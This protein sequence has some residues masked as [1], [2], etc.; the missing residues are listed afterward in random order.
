M[1]SS[2]TLI[3][4][5][6]FVIALWSIGL[7]KVIQDSFRKSGKWGVRFRPFRKWNS[8]PISV[9]PDITCPKC[10][11]DCPKIRLPKSIRQLLWGGVT[12]PNCNQEIDKWGK[13]VS[14]KKNR[15]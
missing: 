5:I 4:I 14:P 12:C 2:S 13:A 9:L 1:N 10:G 15:L 7:L 6:L 8:N 11:E 3:F